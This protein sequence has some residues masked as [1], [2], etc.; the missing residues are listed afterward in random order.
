MQIRAER[1]GRQM[2]D[3]AHPKGSPGVQIVAA[4]LRQIALEMSVYRGAEL[5]CDKAS[6]ARSVMLHLR[7]CYVSKAAILTISAP[8]VSVENRSPA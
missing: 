7:A 5:T 4:K 8:L 6:P 3:R 1:I 2:N